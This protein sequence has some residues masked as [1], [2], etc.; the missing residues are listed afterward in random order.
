MATRLLSAVDVMPRHG[1]FNEWQTGFGRMGVSLTACLRVPKMGSRRFRKLHIEK[2]IK[3]G[4]LNELAERTLF[5][6]SNHVISAAFI[7]FML[8]HEPYKRS[9]PP[10]IG[11]MDFSFS[12]FSVKRLGASS[13]L[14]LFI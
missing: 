3:A 10:H 6:G 7:I 9:A 14:V 1:S 5:L 8:M 12:A 4:A 2:Q 11:F 13:I